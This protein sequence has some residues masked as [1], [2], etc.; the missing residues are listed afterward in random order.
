MFI[1]QIN[2]KKME[3]TKD[4]L[5]SSYN[6]RN[7]NVFQETYKLIDLLAQNSTR[8][9]IRAYSIKDNESKKTLY[10]VNEKYYSEKII[11]LVNYT[12]HNFKK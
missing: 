2:I 8:D 11:A 9:E 4:Y 3:E 5:H 10:E 7:L 6:G 12:I 1:S